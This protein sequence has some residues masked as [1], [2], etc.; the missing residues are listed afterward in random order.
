[1][2]CLCC[3]FAKSGKSDSPFDRSRR[4]IAE[5][6]NQ[7]DTVS[8]NTAHMGYII[9]GFPFD[10][11]SQGPWFPNTHHMAGNTDCTQSRI[12]CLHIVKYFTSDLLQLLTWRLSAM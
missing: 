7:W 1:M 11:C 8:G 9:S 4:S 10:L 3:Q 6:S 12:F 2:N 5:I